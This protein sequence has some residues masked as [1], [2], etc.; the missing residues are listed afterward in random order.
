MGRIHHHREAELNLL[1]RGGVEYLHR[2]TLRRLEPGRLTA[3]WG[4]TPHS[5]VSVEP[6]SEM[7][8]ITVPLGWLWGWEL[9]ERFIRGLMEGRWWVA[10]PGHITRFPLREWVDELAHVLPA[11]QRRLLLEMQGCFLWMAE[12]AG[13]AVAPAKKR[14]GGRVAGGLHRVEAMARCMAERFHEN[15]AIPEIARAAGL[16]PNY[17]MPLFRR[18]CGITIRDYLLQHRLTNAQRLLLM[19]D[20]K[21]V[22]IAF[23]SGFGSL[24]AFYDAFARNLMETPQV[25]RRRMRV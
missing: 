8:W 21:V 1:F 2:G 9:P 17:A 22:D 12:R 11:Q 6:G 7:V 4:S 5:L 19:T 20:D 15:L 13:S 24:S 18:Y 23:A 10:P 16:H 14:P 3:F 25:Y